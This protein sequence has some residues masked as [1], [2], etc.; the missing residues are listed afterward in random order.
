MPKSINIKMRVCKLGSGV[1]WKGAS[2]QKDL[3]QLDVKQCLSV[4]DMDKNYT[5]NLIWTKHWIL[6]FQNSLCHLS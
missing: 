2:K 4:H 1:D 6:V 5:L 3:K